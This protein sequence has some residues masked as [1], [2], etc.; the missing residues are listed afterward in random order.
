MVALTASQRMKADPKW[1]ATG[2]VALFAGLVAALLPAWRIESLVTDI[3][4]PALLPAAAPPLGT[5]FRIGLILAAM[6][7]AGAAT[8]AAVGRFAPT[9]RV[10]RTVTRRAD[11]H[12]DAPVREPVMAMRD[13]GTPFLDVGVRPPEQDIPRD[14]DLPLAA[15]DPTAIPETP[16]TPSE[17]VKPLYR[18]EPATDAAPPVPA[19]P[20]LPDP[21]ADPVIE[22]VRIE[23]FEV[24]PSY[25]QPVLAAVPDIDDAPAITAPE[26]EAT[27]HAL[28][29]RL[30]RGVRRR[31]GGPALVERAH[32]DDLDE[33]LAT[34]RRFAGR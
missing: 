15:F 26:T 6:A 21:E 10:V 18:A 3:G 31:G 28:L 22:H 30:E 14:L 20:P 7:G 4:L 11:R 13:L 17:P 5:T 27:I 8:W 16:L 25:R 2:I 19:D 1:V 9:R 24:T 34:L 33:A 32:S 12:P 29:D 23:T